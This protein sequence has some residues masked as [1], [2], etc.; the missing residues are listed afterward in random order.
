MAAFS[1]QGGSQN[2]NTK[3]IHGS[4]EQP[5]SGAIMD[6]EQQHQHPD[7]HRVQLPAAVQGKAVDL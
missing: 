3:G 6:A 1:Y 7:Q 5:L 4:L 2:N